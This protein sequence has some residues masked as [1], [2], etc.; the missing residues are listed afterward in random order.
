M[1]TKIVKIDGEFSVRLPAEM[2]RQAGCGDVV[3][4][5]LVESGILIVGSNVTHPRAGWARAA[6]LMHSRGEDKLESEVEP[7]R[8]LST[9]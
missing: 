5:H 4:V 1:K 2:L 9:A 8:A 7:A 3:D 6:K